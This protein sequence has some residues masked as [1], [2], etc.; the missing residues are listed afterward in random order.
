MADVVG[1]CALL[2]VAVPALVAGK[3]PNGSD[4]RV[5]RWGRL[6]RRTYLDEIPQL[7]NVLGGSMSLVGPRPI[8]PLELDLFGPRAPSL[9][10]A[11]LQGRGNE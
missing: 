11:A 9:L 6:P 7:F 1:A 4:P 8:V 3:L 10:L 5:T 2:L